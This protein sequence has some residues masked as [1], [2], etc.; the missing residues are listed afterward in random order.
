MTDGQVN[1]KDLQ[2]RRACLG[3]QVEL[4]GART[5]IMHV[6]PT[7]DAPSP[8]REPEPHSPIAVGPAQALLDFER[9]VGQ[10]ADRGDVPE[11]EAH[12]AHKRDRQ[13]SRRRVCTQFGQL[14]APTRHATILSQRKRQRC[15]T[16]HPDA[17]SPQLA[18]GCSSAVSSSKVK[19]T[20]RSSAATSRL[21]PEGRCASKRGPNCG[22]ERQLGRELGGVRHAFKKLLP[23]WH[24]PLAA[25]CKQPAG[26]GAHLDVAHDLDPGPRVHEGHAGGVEIRV[27]RR[28]RR[29]AAAAAVAGVHAARGGRV[30]ARGGRVVVRRLRPRWRAAP[31]WWRV[32]WGRLRE[33]SAAAPAG[34]PPACSDTALAPGSS[35]S[36]SKAAPTCAAPPPPARLWR[37]AAARARASRRARRP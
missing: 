10:R 30:A 5:P 35:S 31:A 8:P 19:P 11:L 23:S 1:L 6:H 4:G 12:L 33:G 22:A 17:C 24:P 9:G 20:P 21:S 15:S 16:P 25:A 13:L 3:R 28:G 27:A 14:W 2:R 37:R 29:V 32:R 36:S 18:C 7:A 26:L 34:P